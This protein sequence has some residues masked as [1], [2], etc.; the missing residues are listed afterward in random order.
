MADALFA[1]VK[2]P[3]G[4]LLQVFLLSEARVIAVRASVTHNHASAAGAVASSFAR[5]RSAN[6]PGNHTRDASQ[7]SIVDG[8]FWA[9]VTAAGGSNAEWDDNLRPLLQTLPE[10]PIATQNDLAEH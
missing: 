6:N 10:H 8:S 5:R 7:Q 4:P 3:R 1:F 9:G 2:I